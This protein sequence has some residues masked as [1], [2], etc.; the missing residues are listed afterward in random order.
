MKKILI[1]VHNDLCLA[2]RDP[3][4]FDWGSL[5]EGVSSI[6]LQEQIY[7]SWITSSVL[8]KDE[9]P[10][11]ARNGSQFQDFPKFFL[12]PGKYVLKNDAIAGYPTCRGCRAYD[13]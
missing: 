8:K 3:T 5:S 13:E 1:T 4:Y 11:K 6:V 7:C 10:W 12:Y 9:V 2:T